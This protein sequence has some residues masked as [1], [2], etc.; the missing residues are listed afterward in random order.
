MSGRP[1]WLSVASLLTVVRHPAFRAGF[2]LLA[3]G[4]AAAVVVREWATFS[5]TATSLGAVPLL[6]A[7]LA[8]A[9]NIVTAG[10]AWRQLVDGPSTPLPVRAGLTVYLVGQLGKFLPGSV[11]NVLAQAELASDHRVPRRHAAGAGVVN[12][13]MAV[14]VAAAL[15][16]PAALVVD[17]LGPLR[18]WFLALTP[19]ALVCLHPFVLNRGL[20]LLLRVARQPAPAVP[21]TGP[22]VLSALAWVVLSWVAAGALVLVLLLGAG[23]PLTWRTLLVSFS[24][25]ALAWVVGFVVVFAPAGAGPREAVLV[26]LLAPVLGTGAALAVVLVARVVTIAVDVL[27]AGLAYLARPRPAVAGG[28]VT[29]PTT[30]AGER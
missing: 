27:V 1:R 4:L 9:A 24:G 16:A 17:G 15:A 28:P 14:I 26:V 13:A 22:R 21:L 3:L 19:A 29:G 18:W 5:A 7:A 30:A 6:L 12:L 8:A 20:A 23:A 2:L 10:M 25:Y 11:W